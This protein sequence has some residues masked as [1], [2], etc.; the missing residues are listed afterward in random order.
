MTWGSMTARYTNCGFA[1][2]GMIHF[3][4][5]AHRLSA[6]LGRFSRTK[7]RFSS[8]PRPKPHLEETK[9]FDEKS[10]VRKPA[11]LKISAAMGCCALIFDSCSVALCTV[12]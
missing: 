12:G 7:L 9:P 1:L 3:L 4:A 2:P 6:P 5:V 10:P 8:K 11:F